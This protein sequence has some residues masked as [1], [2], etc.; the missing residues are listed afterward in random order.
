MDPGFGLMDNLIPQTMGKL[1]QM[2]NMSKGDHYTPNLNESMTVSY[3]S[4]FMQSMS[5]DIK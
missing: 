1:S 2:I 3:K 5:Q 4:E